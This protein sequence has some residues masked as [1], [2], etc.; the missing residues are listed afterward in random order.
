MPDLLL[1]TV[2]TMVHNPLCST[3]H[4]WAALREIARVCPMST[5]SVLL[6][7]QKRGHGILLLMKDMRQLNYIDLHP[8]IMATNGIRLPTLWRSF[9]TMVERTLMPIAKLDM[10]FPDLR[11][12]FDTTA[13]IRVS[14]D[15]TKMCLIDLDS[16]IPLANFVELRMLHLDHNSFNGT[17]PESYLSAGNGRLEEFSLNHNSLTGYVPDKIEIWNKMSKLVL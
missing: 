2:S 3:D 10:V 11:I 1:K 15:G 4:N 9:C 14:T 13:N 12:G 17:I 7:T 6:A 16:I 8:Q 5:N